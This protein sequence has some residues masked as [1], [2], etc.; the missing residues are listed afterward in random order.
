MDKVKAKVRYM[1]TWVHGYIPS[2]KAINVP[3]DACENL[4][5]SEMTG[6]PTICTPH[7]L[8]PASRTPSRVQSSQVTTSSFV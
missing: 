5:L 4:G 8:Y 2:T 6:Y 7:M 1:D 3:A